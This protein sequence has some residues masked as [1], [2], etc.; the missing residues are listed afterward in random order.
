MGLYQTKKFLH[1]QGNHQN[2]KDNPRSGRTYSPNLPYDPTIPLL[3][4]YLKKLKTLI[5]KNTCTPMFTAALFTIAKIWKQP[6]CP[7]VDEWIKKLWYIY[8]MEYYLALKQENHTFCDNMMDLGTIT[9]SEISQSEKDK[10][11]MISLI[12]GI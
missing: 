5:W 1:S 4:I 11:H 9:L 8:T 12:C 2:E 10:Y 6:N 3:G 7:S